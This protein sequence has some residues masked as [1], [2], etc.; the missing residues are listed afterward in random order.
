[1]KRTDVDWQTIDTAPEGERLLLYLEH[2]EKGNGE[3]AVGMIFRN[4]GWP[5][6]CYW[7][8]GGPNSGND[9]DEAP[10]HWALLPLDPFGREI[11]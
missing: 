5:L 9:V 3:I 8:W 2:G 1:V 6:D 7:T 10:T 4:E 11:A